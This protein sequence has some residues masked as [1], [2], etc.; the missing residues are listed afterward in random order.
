MRELFDRVIFG[1]A[2]FNLL[3]LLVACGDGGSGSSGTTGTLELGLTDAATSDYQA[4][5]VTIAEVQV[6]K[7]GEGESG[8]QTAVMPEQTYN[9]LE[10][11]N[12]VIAT[13]G[14]GELETGQYGQMRL[15]LGEQ[16]DGSENI[17]NKTHPYAN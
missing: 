13:L 6:K 4:M 16:S 10:L 12:G 8:W 14:I 3:I 11:V 15:I 2:V 9:L 7:Q 5:Y 17:L 1:L